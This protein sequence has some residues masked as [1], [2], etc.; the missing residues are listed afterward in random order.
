MPVV[1]LIPRNGADTL[2]RF[3]DHASIEVMPRT[4]AK[5]ESFG[6]LLAPGTRVYLAHIEGTPFDD[7][8]ATARRLT[9]EGFAVMPHVPARLIADRATLDR[10]L[11]GY[12]ETG[13]T[14]ALV[15]AGGPATPAGAFHSSIQ[16]LETGLFQSH[17][18]SRLH[19][20][21]HPEG[22]RDIDPAGSTREVDAALRWKQRFAEDTGT[23]MAI[24]TQFAFAAQPV[25]DWAERLAGLGITLPVHVGVAGPAKLQ[26][27]IK[28]SIACGVGASLGV[29]QKRA[30]DITRLLKPFEPTELLTELATYRAAHPE[31]L[32]RQAHIFPLGGIAASARYLG[33]KTGA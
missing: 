21:G 6:A 2:R 5:V 22:N 3:L 9:A 23:D 20:A 1:N 24:V 30:K 32:V 12:A 26:T 11:G 28:Y 18:F 29:L 16:L 19:V 25:T 13:I 8:L 31:S 4:A 10:M 7:M 27:L 14:Q 15:L 17:G 33:D